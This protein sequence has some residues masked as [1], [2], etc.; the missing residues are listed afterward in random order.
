MRHKNDNLWS[1]QLLAEVANKVANSKSKEP[2]SG[3]KDTAWWTFIPIEHFI[4]PLLHC[5]IGIGNDL[6]DQ[7]RD[8]VDERI[9]CLSKEER[10]SRK[11]AT[12]IAAEIGSLIEDRVVF[13]SSENGKDL[14]SLKSRRRYRESALKKLGAIEVVER[15]TVANDEFSVISLLKDV[16]SLV[17]RSDAGIEEGSPD[18]IEC[19]AE[20]DSG[21]IT[22]A[23]ARSPALT[24]TSPASPD[25]AVPHAATAASMIDAACDRFKHELGEIDKEV[26]PLEKARRKK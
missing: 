19:E 26:Q 10:E 11:A 5:L 22:S 18:D 20:E 12:A 6:L 16:E 2:I 21:K 25:A 24:D 4:I 1:Y 9:A 3:V 8:V 23:T 7:F 13:D 14:K 17:D 15:S